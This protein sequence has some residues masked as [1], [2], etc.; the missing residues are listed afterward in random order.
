MKA[1]A[2]DLDPV[3][4]YEA[5]QTTRPRYEAATRKKL[6]QA[7][8][9]KYSPLRWVD[10]KQAQAK[11]INDSMEENAVRQLA[12]QNRKLIVHPTHEQKNGQI[13]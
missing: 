9:D 12:R 13:R 10:A 4:L 11:L 7:Y 2:A 1:Q 6:E 8:G 5:R 3:K